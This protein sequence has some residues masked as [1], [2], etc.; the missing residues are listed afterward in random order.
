MSAVQ[1]P[2]CPILSRSVTFPTITD[3]GPFRGEMD[4]EDY[5]IEIS[6]LRV[7]CTWWHHEEECCSMKLMAN[8]AWFF[9]ERMSQP[10]VER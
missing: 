4:R 2:I 6:C 1:P 9:K 8:F 3:D 7:R 5:L 10:E